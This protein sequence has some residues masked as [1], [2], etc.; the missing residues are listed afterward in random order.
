MTMKV[1]G[2]IPARS[3]SKGVPDKNIKTIKRVP[4]LEFSVYAAV[5]AK[6]CGILDSVVVSTD[7]KHYLSIVDDYAIEKD[8]L[9]PRALAADNSPTIDA[10]LDVLSWYE[11]QHNK[12][13]DAVM[14]L[15]PTSPFRTPK[16]IKDAID[17]M[18]D[19][20]MASCVASICKLGDHHPLRIKRMSDSGQLRDFYDEYVEPE[21][22]RR[23]DFRPDAYIRNG[24]VYLTTTKT[25]VNDRVI[26]GS[27]VAG[28]E[29][30]QANSIN[31]DEHL[32]YLIAKASLEYDG[33]RD[34]LSF[35][36]D[37]INKKGLK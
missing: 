33:F 21:H 36:N 20:P 11:G 27:W 16:H 35:F 1:L 17:L 24:A 29:M 4:L 25:L 8:Y 9:R 32:D 34:D 5:Q 19:K 18:I 6:N 30:P 10:I 2:F 28:M 12:S 13:F 3:G 7:A 22:S 23:Q 14:T 15:Q 37:L 26:R 31:V